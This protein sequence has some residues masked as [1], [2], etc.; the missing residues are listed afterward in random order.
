M[1]YELKCVNS[2]RVSDLR[3]VFRPAFGVTGI[4]DDWYR[5][6]IG[7]IV[8]GFGISRSTGENVGCTWYHL[9]IPG[10]TGEKPGSTDGKSGST[11]N[12]SGA[13]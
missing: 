11:W 7:V 5:S 13:D 1:Q 12:H 3:R 8:I 4:S 6:T 10:S 9:G 2:R